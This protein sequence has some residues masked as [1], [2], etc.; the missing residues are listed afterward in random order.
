MSATPR[1]PLRLLH[2]S[3]VHLGGYEPDLARRA[4]E[5]VVDAVRSTGAGALLVAGDL[6][7]H[8]RVADAEVAFFLAQVARLDVPVVVLPGNHDTVDAGS[9]Y[10]RPAFAA[11]PPNLHVLDD[12]QGRTLELPGLGLVLWGRATRDHTPA[13]RPLQG[14]PPRNGAPWYVALAH[15]HLL[16]AG[17]GEHR[18]SPIAPQ[19][20]AAAPC[21]YVALGHWDRFADV[22]QGGVRAC[23]SGAPHWTPGR[24]GLL[25]HVALVHLTPEEG[26]RVSRLPLG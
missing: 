3:D 11:A 14:V 24:Y 18:S 23:Y 22:S 19:E 6:F 5:A 21:D 7:D 16:E 2:T 13:F 9:V 15:G 8:S 12:P 25:G 26:A 17:A 10:Q 4:L 1:R 20:I